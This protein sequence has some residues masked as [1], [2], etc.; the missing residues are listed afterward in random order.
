MDNKISLD[1]STQYIQKDRVFNICDY[2]QANKQNGSKIDIPSGYA[3]I[4]YHSDETKPINVFYNNDNLGYEYSYKISSVKEDNFSTLTKDIIQHYNRA[5]SVESVES[6]QKVSFTLSVLNFLYNEYTNDYVYIVDVKLIANFT[7][8]IAVFSVCKSF[9]N[10]QNK[11]YSETYQYANDTYAN[12]CSNKT[13]IKMS[14]GSVVPC[15]FANQ[16]Q[17][18]CYEKNVTIV[19]T[20][21]IIDS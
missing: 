7:K 16:T 3:Y 9:S 17:C 18:S 21:L 15:G 11:Q 1:E 19:K 12:N 20:E 2:H 13:I 4:Y 10:P 8:K 5:I 6:K 14:T